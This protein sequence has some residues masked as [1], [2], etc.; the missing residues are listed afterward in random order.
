LRSLRSSLKSL[1]NAALDLLYPNFCGVCGSFLF[2][3][4]HFVACKECWR[5]NFVPYIGEKCSVCGHPLEFLPGAPGICKRCLEKKRTFN[6]DSVFYFTLYRGLPEFAIKELKFSRLK[7]VAQVIGETISGHFLQVLSQLR[8]D[9]IVPVPVS[10]ET[11]RERGF[12]QTEEIL[13]GARIPYVPLL[14]KPF[15]PEKQSTL[16]FKERSQNVRGVF[17]IKKEF[18]VELLGKSVLIFDDVFTTG[19]TANEIAG[20]LK[21]YGA[22]KVYVYTVC[23]TPFNSLSEKITG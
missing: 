17:R 21:R 22:R 2:K 8:V 13:K 11:L 14:E 16:S 5:E 7:P 15:T 23:Y 12:N 19:A 6:F 1:V 4:H 9:L 20:L 18:K 10:R 3:E